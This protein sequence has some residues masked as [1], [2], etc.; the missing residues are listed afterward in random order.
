MSQIN[1]SYPGSF[2]IRFDLISHEI[3]PYKSE[4]DILRAKINKAKEYSQ[5]IKKNNLIPLIGSEEEAEEDDED[6]I[7]K[8]VNEWM[9]LQVE[10]ADAREKFQEKIAAK[11][12]IGNDYLKDAV[13]TIKQDR[14]KYLKMKEEAISTNPVNNIEP[15]NK[16]PTILRGTQSQKIIPGKYDKLPI[17]NTREQEETRLMKK[18]EAS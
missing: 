16:M 1:K 10:K 14:E 13:K 8:P 4:I 18:K 7:K 6:R 12:G 2:L 9:K 17:I 15:G 5:T 3:N 11:Q